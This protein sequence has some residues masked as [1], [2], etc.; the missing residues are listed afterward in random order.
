MP[1]K[2]TKHKYIK[3]KEFLMV[4]TTGLQVLLFYSPTNKP[5][6]RVREREREREREQASMFRVASERLALF[7]PGG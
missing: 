7:S 2:P 1:V 3:S 5:A 4:L 6:Q